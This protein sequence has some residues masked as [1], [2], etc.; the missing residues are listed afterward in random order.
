MQLE[1]GLEASVN[2][3]VSG[4]DT[5]AALGS[6]DVEVL[7]TPAVLALA[8]QAAVAAIRDTLPADRTSVGTWAEIFHTAPTRVGGEVSAAA[9]VTSVEGSRVEFT[10]LVREG[11]Q[12]VARVEH[13][14]AVVRRDR[15]S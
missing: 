9:R 13:R 14:R 1:A 12:E 2:L 7:G 6:G 10:V 4:D 11:E 5:A 15:F 8:E 3:K